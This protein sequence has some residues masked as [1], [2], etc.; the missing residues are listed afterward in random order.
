MGE[1]W[2]LLGLTV[3][4]DG[5]GHLL[6]REGVVDVLYTRIGADFRAAEQPTRTLLRSRDEATRSRNIGR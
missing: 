2:V 3:G 4:L 6:S 1:G 5:G